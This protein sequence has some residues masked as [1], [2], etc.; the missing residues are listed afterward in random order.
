MAPTVIGLISDTHL[1]SLT[2]QLLEAV[3]THFSDVHMLLHAGDVTSP[4][5]LD[6]LEARGWKVLAVRGNM[7]L[8]PELASRLP[9]TRILELAGVKIGLCHGWGAPD[10]IRSRVLDS[11]GGPDH[12][13]VIVYGHTHHP[14][15]RVERG[16]RFVNPGSPT[17]QRYAPYRS[18]ARLV[19][20]GPRDVEVQ[21]IR[22]D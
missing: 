21:F 7:D 9:Q 11:L 13:D 3:E 6:E 16:I 1:D 2:P 10:G 8:H 15:D 4:G 18:L 14:D 5:L 12:I 22:L 20:S 19:I 17:D